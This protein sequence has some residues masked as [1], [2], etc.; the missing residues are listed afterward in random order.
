MR[1]RTFVGLCGAGL[2]GLLRAPEPARAAD[3]TVSMAMTSSF[4]PGVPDRLL[5]SVTRPFKTILESATGMRGRIVPGGKACTLAKKIQED[6]I[7]VGIF[8]GIEF[9]WAR[10]INPNLRP[11]V[12]CVNQERTLRALLLVRASSKVKSPADLRRTTLAVAAGTYEH[13]WVFLRKKCLGGTAVKTFFD[14][15]TTAID[16][17]EALDDVVDNKV[18]AALVDGLAWQSYRAAKPGC[19][20]KLRVLR[21]SEEFP[22]AVI[23]DQK[24]RFPDDLTR[25]FRAAMLRARDDRRGRRL[26]E[27]AR[28][29]A[30]EAVPDDYEQLCSDIVKTYPPGS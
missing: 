18:Q 8:Q 26:L 23:A 29:S 5:D 30:F 13:C 16:V 14:K 27:L 11:V 9:A 24:G 6:K 25:R 19:A 2:V 12:V 28:L 15:L 20:R 3:D 10:Q 21:I 7:Q 17:E 1:R 4:F 22:C